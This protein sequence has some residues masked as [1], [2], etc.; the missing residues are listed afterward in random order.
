[1]TRWRAPQPPRSPYITA[2]GFDALQAEQKQLWLRRR[3]VTQKVAEAA[4]QGDRSENADYT[5]NKKLLRE[6]DRRIR[7][8]QKRLPVLKVV[9]E[10][11]ADPDRIYFGAWVVLETEDGAELSC[12]IVGSDEVDPK[13]SWISVDS[14]MAKALLKRTVDE[15]V[16]V[17]GPRGEQRYLILAVHYSNVSP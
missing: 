16:I 11:P 5:Y 6:I 9:R 1:M 4:A 10:Q 2:D 12:R 3:E 17:H 7:F 14:P 15:E 13:R 8:L